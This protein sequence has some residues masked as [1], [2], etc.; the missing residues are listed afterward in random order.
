LANRK[1]ISRFFVIELIVVF[2]II[3]CDLLLKNYSEDN[4]QEQDVIL[5]KGILSLTY[6]TNSGAAFGIFQN[7]QTFFKILT[8][9]AL[10]IFMYYLYRNRGGNIILRLS[11][12]FIISGT[13]GNFIDRVKYNYVR[14][15]LRF[16][17]IDFPIFNIAD[18]ALTVGVT[19]FAIYFLFIFKEP[20]KAQPLKDV[21]ERG[22]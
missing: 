17:F 7:K 22:K 15:M 16:D 21:T 12:A 2:V 19:L 10:C 11:F 5:L 8:V 1:F 6:T 14:D 9:I 20:E 4:L 3:A 13:T 18:S